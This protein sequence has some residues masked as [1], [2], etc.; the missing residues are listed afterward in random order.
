MKFILLPTD[1]LLF[2]LAIAIFLLL[3]WLRRYPHWRLAWQQVLRN[4]IGM[5]ALVIL[6]TYVGIGLLDSIHFEKTGNTSTQEIVSLFDLMVQPLG[7]Q[8]E[9]TYSAPFAIHAFGKATQIL[10]NGTVTQSY[11]RLEFG[12]AALKNP[13]QKLRDIFQ[14]TGIAAVM[15]LLIW[16]CLCGS[17]IFYLAKQNK[18]KFSACLKRIVSGKTSI[19]WRETF[20]TLAFI[21]QI[22]FIA[23]AL[24]THYHI[25]G[26]DKVGNDIFYE[27]LKSIR[28]GLVIGTLTT[29]IM[30]PFAVLLGTIAGYLGGWLDDGIQYVYTTL[31][32]IPGVL[33]I[34]AA[35]LALQIY[36]ENHPQT[37]PSLAMRADIRLLALCTILGITSW[38]T[39]C[40]LIR[41]ETLKLREMDFIAAAIAL[42][43]SRTKIILKHI[44]PN[45]MH[46]ILIT[47]VLDF[48]GLVLAEAVLSYVGVGVDPS[49]ISWGNMINSAR[50]ELARDPIVWWPLVAAFI[51]MFVFVLA[52]NLFADA[53]RDAFDPR[54]RNVE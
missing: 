12:G 23:Y 40:R 36:I 4:K 32:S 24:A 52:A 9:V 50:L 46:I 53:V 29:L 47:V 21:I 34:T 11:P 13:N 31:S 8:D 3:I 15:A 37:F 22:I 19:A 38:T 14:R 25:L 44:L 17:W 30:L 42:G 48:S 41:A 33:L 51:F 54:L 43:T 28:T 2:F 7:Q 27:T 35:I 1:A 18:Q 20:I 49:T 10:P 26:T 5:I 39:L 45:V 6:I 16:L